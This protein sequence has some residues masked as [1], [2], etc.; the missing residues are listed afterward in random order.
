MPMIRITHHRG[1]FT[2]AQKAQIAEELSK[3][4]L[5][6]EFGT[7]TAG[8]QAV[9]YVMFTEV[10]P[11]TNWFVGG[12][13]EVNPPKAGRFLFDAYIPVGAATQAEKTELQ[14][15]IHK[16]VAEILDLD[17]AFPSRIGDWVLIHEIPEGNWGAGGRTV[18]VSDIMSVGGA[19]PERSAYIEAFKAAE[20]R[21]R[22]A[23]GYPAGSA[24]V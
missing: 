23:H 10:D 3:A 14:T 11:K 21:A 8:G 16:A 9:S 15:T 6:A 22:D 2:E 19:L 18:G 24:Y 13:L 12:K 7:I 17:A 4:I 1:A 5:I 20:Q